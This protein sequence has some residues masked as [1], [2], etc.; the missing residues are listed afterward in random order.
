MNIERMRSIIEA[1][2]FASD[3]PV[4]L[5]TLAQV[6]D[7]ADKKDLAVLL[8]NLAAEW[9]GLNR[10]FALVE[11]AGGW[12]FR[13]KS[14]LAPWVQRTKQERP[15]K[16]SRAALETLSIIAYKQPI[17]RPEIEDL[18]GVDSGAVV[19]N[20]LDRNLVKIVGKKDAPG[21]PVVF[22]TTERFLEVFSLRDLGSLPSLRDLKELEDGDG[23]QLALPTGEA[24]PAEGEPQAEPEVIDDSER[25]RR[26]RE[27]VRGMLGEMPVKHDE[28]LEAEGTE[29]LPAPDA[30][31][32]ALAEL[33]KALKR[34]K[35]V[36]ERTEALLDDAERE[37]IEKVTTDNDSTTEAAQAAAP[38]AS[39]PATEPAATASDA[40]GDKPGEAVNTDAGA[41]ASEAR[42]PETLAGDTVA[43]GASPAAAGES[44][45]E[46]SPAEVVLD[47]PEHGDETP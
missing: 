15:S 29:G 16:L 38:E 18:R 42:A 10:G 2:I 36:V 11:V 46:E 8:D 44:P 25:R 45:A 17:T 4:P 28:P 14:E 9:R 21:K 13:T 41:P 31:D 19:K 26:I 34:R 37:Y 22:G 6:L 23:E 30:D 3:K 43:E 47:E 5:E 12:Q 33:E 32:D 1:V 24:A 39:P 27:K 35:E 20:L 40:T 7:D